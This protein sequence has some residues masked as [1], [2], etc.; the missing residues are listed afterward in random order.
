[1]KI[2]YHERK[3]RGI[4]NTPNGQVS[5][6]TLFEYSQFGSLLRATYQGGSI[7][8]GEIIGLVQDD[9]SLEFVYHH[10]DSDDKLKSGYC[11]SIPEFLPDG[12]IRLHEIWEWTY[13]G[14]GKGNS[15]VEEW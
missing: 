4:D 15:I 14:E 6:E 5:D 1:M 3:F 10:I 9:Y 7:K 12:R 13:G 8:H 11:K 2:N